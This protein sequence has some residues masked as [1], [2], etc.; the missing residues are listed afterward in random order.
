MWGD[1]SLWFWFAFP[2]WL[3]SWAPFHVLVGHFI[4]SLEKCLFSSSAHFLI[5]FFCLLLSCMSSL[6]A[7]DINRLGDIR[8]AN[9]CSHS[10]GYLFIL[11]IAFFN[12]YFLFIYVWLHWVFVAARRLSLVVVSGGYSSFWCAGFSLWWL[13]L[14]Q[15][16]GSRHMGF[17]SC[18]TWAQ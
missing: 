10:V 16:T 7:L 5:V 11:L 3:V 9:I 14:L 6:Y 18:G 8:F 13:L 2:W 12:Y 17:S 4:S 15:S 1:I